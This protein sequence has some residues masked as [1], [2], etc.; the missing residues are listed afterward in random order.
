AW[1]LKKPAPD[2]I[3]G[4]HPVSAEKTPAWRDQ[5]GAFTAG[6]QCKPRVRFP[7]RPGPRTMRRQRGLVL[8]ACAKISIRRANPAGRARPP[9]AMNNPRGGH[10]ILAGRNKTPKERLN[11]RPHGHPRGGT[12][13]LRASTSSY[14]WPWKN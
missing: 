3:R 6:D 10:K 14:D 9:P 1:I 13:C 2:L 5:T 4:G 12:K 8:R 7:Q 11:R